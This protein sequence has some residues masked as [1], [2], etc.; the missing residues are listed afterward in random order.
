MAPFKIGYFVGS[1]ATGSINRVLANALIKL[2]PED[3]QFSEIP[4]RDLPLYSYDYD[5]DFPAEGRALKEAIESS[6]GILFVSPEYNRSIPGALK[7]AIDWGSRPWGTNSFARKPTGIIG[8]SPG[9]IGTAVM[10]SSMR[11]VLS[12]LDAPQLNAPEA[13]IQYKP[14]A[15]DDDG[16]LRDEGT[17]KFLRHYIEEYSAFVAR[18]LAANAP[19]HIGDLEPDADKLSR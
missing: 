1:L 9:S 11:S 14:D 5:A 18:V 6:D 7:N 17:A 10:Q 12:F 4:I 3:L 8:A 2:A 15:F 16:E 13:Y 19:G